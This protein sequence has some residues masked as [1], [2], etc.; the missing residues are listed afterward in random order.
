MSIVEDQARAALKL[1]EDPELKFSILDLGLI[2]NVVFSKETGRIHV[3]MTLTSLMCP[4]Q[5]F[6]QEAITRDLLA[7]PEVSEV[8]ID[9]TFDP[10]WSPGKAA[11]YIQ[12]HF[13][14]LGI[15]LTR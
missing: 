4:L 12:E 3:T 7:L 2:Y 9:F 14:L 8:T 13:V 1:I 15:P 10:P 11:S 5:E 6:F